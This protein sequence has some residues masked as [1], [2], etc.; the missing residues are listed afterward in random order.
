MK[1]Q[2]DLTN[3]ELNRTLVNKINSA[4]TRLNLI[5]GRETPF[6][7]AAGGLFYIPRWWY[8][9]NYINTLPGLRGFWTGGR[10]AGHQGMQDLSQMNH[11]M[12]DMGTVLYDTLSNGAELGYLNG[13]NAYF[14]ATDNAEHSITGSE[15]YIYSYIRGLTVGGWF[16]YNAALPGADRD[17]ISK[18]IT[19]GN[20]RSY[21]MFYYNTPSPPR[22]VFLT[23]SNGT[24]VDGVYSNTSLGTIAY[25]TWYFIVGRFDPA[26]EW[27]IFTNGLWRKVTTGDWASGAV[28]GYTSIFDSTAPLNIGSYD[29][30]TR[31]I[32]GHFSL[33]FLCAH[34]LPDW[35]I[36][37]IYHATKDIFELGGF[38]P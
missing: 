12:A 21:Q 6:G 31:F 28:S 11:T 25:D 26:T 7:R 17:F 4:H 23:S 27:A 32:K 37:H 5:E 36:E 35:Q 30:T 24:N 19:S 13:T 9:V 10:H 34:A 38:S 18:W 16:R 20:Q 33:V 2:H 22:W 1:K 8:A 3:L 29:G 14:T 15:S